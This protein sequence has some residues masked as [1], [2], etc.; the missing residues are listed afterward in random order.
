M[1]SCSN[2]FR[3]TI[4]S[5]FYYFC[6]PYSEAFKNMTTAPCNS[7][8][9]EVPIKGKIVFFMKHFAFVFVKNGQNLKS[10]LYHTSH[11]LSTV[12]AQH[13]GNMGTF[14]KSTIFS[15]ANSCSCLVMEDITH[16][17]CHGVLNS[18]AFTLTK[19]SCFIYAFIK[20][21]LHVFCKDPRN[22]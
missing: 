9:W 11:N 12:K 2:H 5:Y 10:A 14:F 6:T 8:P 22:M 17:R 15:A 20:E 13:S 16:E 3:S 19:E 18:T 1:A 4:K 7:S 21:S